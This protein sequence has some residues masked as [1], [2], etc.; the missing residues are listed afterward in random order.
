LALA[1]NGFS[2]K[3]LIAKGGYG[4]MY[5]GQWQNQDVAVKLFNVKKNFKAY[6]K[7]YVCMYSMQMQTHPIENIL[8]LLAFSHTEED[9]CLVHLYMPNGS[10]SDRLKLKNDTPPLK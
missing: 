9:L 8:D 2:P 4:E 10:V 7:G 3:N 1:C 6:F 5:R